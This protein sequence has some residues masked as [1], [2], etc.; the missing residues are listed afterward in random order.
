MAGAD[1]GIEGI[2]PVP[3]PAAGRPVRLLR[4][5]PVPDPDVRP[6]APAARRLPARRRGAPRLDGPVRRHARAPR[7]AARLVPRQRPVDLHVA[8]ARAPDPPAR[9]AAAG[10]ARRDRRRR[11]RR[12]GAGGRR[13]RRRLRPDA[14]GDGVRARR[15]ASGRSVPGPRS[16]RS[17]PAPPI[18]PARDGRHRG[19]LHRAP[20]GHQGPPADERSRAA[21]RRLGRHAAR[22][23][24][25]R[26]ARAGQGASPSASRRCSAPRSRRSSRGPWTRPGTRAG[27][28]S[29]SPGCSCAPDGWIEPRSDPC[30]ARPSPIR[31]ASRSCRRD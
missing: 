1:P 8:L 27:S 24:D 2:A 26:G 5:L 19:A 16:S 4:R 28:G 25:P 30:P 13:Q 9:R 7:A 10:L 23:G 15:A 31:P 6:G 12:V 21:G 11:A 3:V 14:G 20:D 18:V 29:G 22:G 17:A